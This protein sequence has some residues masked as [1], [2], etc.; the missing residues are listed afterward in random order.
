MADTEYTREAFR[1]RALRLW[2]SCKGYYSEYSNDTPDVLRAEF[3]K[4]LAALPSASLGE[5]REPSWPAGLLDRIKAA[6]QRIADNHAPRRIPADPHG[7]VD[8]VL[9]EVRYLIEGN[10][11][12]FWIKDAASPASKGAGGGSLIAGDKTEGGETSRG[13]QG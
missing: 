4:L 5:Q 11:P 6:E 13:G 3:V 12:P 1:E 9:A 7:D 8:L 2:D 10:W